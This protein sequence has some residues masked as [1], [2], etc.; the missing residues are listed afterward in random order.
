[1][2]FETRTLKHASVAAGTMIWTVGVT[3]HPDGRDS[4]ALNSM[5]P[6]C[7]CLGD[8]PTRPVPRG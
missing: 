2:T 6:M 5:P 1:M 8:G 7:A 4:C 3:E